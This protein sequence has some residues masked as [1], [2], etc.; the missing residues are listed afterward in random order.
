VT[1]GRERTVWVLRQGKPE[2]VE[3]T[4]GA[5]DGRMTEVVGGALEPDMALITASVAGKS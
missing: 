1:E 5:S 3:I 4:I 2:A